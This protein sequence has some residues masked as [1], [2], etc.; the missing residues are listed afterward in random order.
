M[1]LQVDYWSTMPKSESSDRDRD[2]DKKDKRD[3]SSKISLKTS[4]RSL[5]VSR[6]APSVGSGPSS[7]MAVTSLVPPAFSMVVV[8]KEK[9]QK[10]K[11]G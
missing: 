5:V 9:K 6:M 1:D 4:V 7:G 11:L 8:T 2:K 3:A 10:S